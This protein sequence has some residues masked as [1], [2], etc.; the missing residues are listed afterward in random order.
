MRQIGWKGKWCCGS[1]GGWGSRT[2]EAAQA[3]AFRVS[4]FAGKT[5][6][7]DIGAASRSSRP[8]YATDRRMLEVIAE[9]H[10]AGTIS[11]REGGVRALPDAVRKRFGGPAELIAELEDLR[12]A[13]R[14]R[15]RRLLT[16]TGE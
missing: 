11:T 13:T 7:D 15:L 14:E 5:T 4:S 3:S 1:K 8:C 16:L 2:A 10:A 6:A 9:E 12:A